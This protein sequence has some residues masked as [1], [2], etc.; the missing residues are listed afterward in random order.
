M[1]ENQHLN[2]LIIT[3]KA[4]AARRIAFILSDG[5]SKQKRQKGLSYLEFGSDASKNY[6]VPLSG[7]VV[8]I[9]FP[10]ELNDWNRTELEKLIDAGIVK[11]VTNKVAYNSLLALASSLEKVII[12]TDYDREGELIG[13]EALEILENDAFSRSG[14]RPEVLRA[15][16]S[17]LTQEEVKNAFSD[18]TR[19]DRKLADSASARE[20]IDLI[21]G[22]VLTR[23]FSLVSHRLGK[24]FL[25]I[26][27]VQTP[28]LAMIVKRELEIR[29]FKPQPYW[30][31]SITFRKRHDFEARFRDQPIFS[32]DEAK[33]IFSEIDG[34]SGTVE[35]F[36]TEEQRIPR[37]IPFNTTE[38]LREAS[39]IG[40]PP[41]KAMT[42]AETLYTR[43]LIS[44]PRTDNTVYQR[45][46]NLKGVLKKLQ[47]SE[48]AELATRVL[49]LEQIR[50]SRGRTETTDHPPI[51]PVSAPKKGELKGDYSKIYELVVRRFLAT[52][53][54]EGKKEVST[55]TIDVGGY[56]FI[57]SG[58]KVIEPGWLDLYP[59]RRVQEAILDKLETGERL[60]ARD[61]K[62]IREE[63]KPPP[64]Y[65][66]ASL[67]KRMEEL[68][69]GTKSTRHEIIDKLVRRGFIEGNPVRPTNLGIALVETLLLVESKVT[70]PDMTAELE[71]EMDR[72]AKGELEKGQVVENSRRMLREVLQQFRQHEDAVRNTIQKSLRM[73]DDLG[74]CPV[75]GT[76]V[77]FIRNKELGK[78]K[79]DTEGCRID[80]VV[81]IRGSIQL[82]GELCPVCSLPLIKVIRKG[83][84]PDIRCVDPGCSYNQQKDALGKCPKDGGTLLVRQSKFGKR[85]LGCSN[86]PN[87]DVTYALPQMGMLKGT[88][89]TCEFCDAPILVSL[90][91]KRRWKFCP[92]IDCQFNKK[93]MKKVGSV[94]KADS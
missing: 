64:R 51:Y 54:L 90:R 56:K 71:A 23:F 22:A 85:F 3:E 9:D 47:S 86:F 16:F 55:A 42:I 50:P 82:S 60:D 88:G 11:S 32:E 41:G 83:Q 10:K 7:H 61:W 70:E 14:Q 31:I 6:V 57:A 91:G 20:E 2:T 73:G 52:L 12:A 46:I 78:I 94:Q 28:T 58:V 21:W 38:F 67:I 40:V 19:L 68:N 63:T 25:S 81:K 59:Y 35:E 80:F 76:P 43:G 87:C 48:F 1:K 15:R 62:L 45:S 92:K 37:P 4:D 36:S 29:K 44:Y 84:S 66:L 27:R 53:Y 26:G 72:I 74:V 34:K 13:A 77:K 8:E 79:C 5:E 24:N 93:G 49:E 65:D 17:A 69:L 18:L 33:R 89:E 39:R 30:N 75:H